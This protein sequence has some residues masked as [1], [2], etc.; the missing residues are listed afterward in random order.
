MDYLE[1]LEFVKTKRHLIGQTVKGVTIDELIICP[2]N[3]DY[4]QVFKVKYCETLSADFAITPFK[5]EDVEV[6]VVIG[7][8]YLKE[9]RL[10]IEWKTVD[11][12][13]GNLD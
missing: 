5:A 13:E 12:A 7:K 4:F 8:K 11:W 10:A 9:N 6:A 1:A 3:P 2:T